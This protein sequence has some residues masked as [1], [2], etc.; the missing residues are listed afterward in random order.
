MM[1]SVRSL[2]CRAENVCAVIVTYHPDDN[3]RNSLSCVAQ[4]V[5]KVV[6]VDN[7]SPAETVASLQKL[8]TRHSAHLIAN[9]DNRGVATAL[10]QG[11]ER[12]KSQ[13]YRWALTLDQDTMPL[14]TMVR[15]LIGIY[16]QCDFR[17]SI[18]IIG[19]NYRNATTATASLTAERFKGK[20]WL[21]R[22]AV[23]TSGSLLS[24][25]AFED[26][27]PFRDEFFIDFVDDEYCLRLRSRNYRILI[28]RE[29]LMTHALGVYT[30]VRLLRWTAA[31]SNHAP[32]RRYYSTRNR[33]ALLR[34]YGVREPRWALDRLRRLVQEVLFIALFEPSKKKKLWAMT[35]GLRHFLRGRS[36]KWEGRI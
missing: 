6:I 31:Y 22:T 24:L 23:I 29:P 30:P 3:L 15:D 1:Q 14:P 8:A 26:V 32:L 18:G 28:S 12:A 36:G 5:A 17:E 21:E 27:G 20:L 19:A 13:G 9:N 2:S 34:E 10:N 11:V 16:K 4:Q 33:L 7:G 35:W 25:A